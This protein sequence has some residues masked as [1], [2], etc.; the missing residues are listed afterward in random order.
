VRALIDTL[1]RLLTLPS[2]EGVA[3]FAPNGA[4]YCARLDQQVGALERVAPSV[5][6]WFRVVGSEVR[7]LEMRSQKKSLLWFRAGSGSL[8]VAADPKAHVASLASRIA[9]S[10]VSLVDGAAPEPTR[11]SRATRPEDAPGSIGTPTIPAPIGEPARE[12]SLVPLNPVV[13]FVG[14]V[15]EQKAPKMR[16]KEGAKALILVALNA[17][18]E[19][20]ASTLGGPVRRNYFTRARKQIAPSG[21]LYAFELELDGRLRSETLADLNIDDLAPQAARWCQKFIELVAV[22]E[23]AFA[24]TSL[25]SLAPEGNVLLD[26]AGFLTLE[27]A[28]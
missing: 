20:A 16:D 24:A 10:I 22:I 13:T 5:T 27:E 6:E 11:F 28:P 8:F 4:S 19:R 23:P 7:F 9:L 15:P 18:S 2:V 12:I 26:A 1:Q 17:L 25:H 21:P 14:S 3:Y